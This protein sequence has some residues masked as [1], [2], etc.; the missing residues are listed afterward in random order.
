LKRRA[1]IEAIAEVV[2]RR[3]VQAGRLDLWIMTHN[4]LE[5]VDHHEAR[6][7]QHQTLTAG[8][9]IPLEGSPSSLDDRP[10]WALRSDWE[11]FRQRLMK[12]R[13]VIDLEEVGASI[14]AANRAIPRIGRPVGTGFQDRKFVAEAFELLKNGGAKSANEAAR[15]IVVQHGD[16]I[17]GANFDAKQTR[18]RKAVMKLEGNGQ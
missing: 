15:I 14:K 1:E 5:K 11:A 18:I 4:G 17:G 16:K 10:L 2:I 6:A 3:A 12:D 7:I 8:R 13:G 9:Y